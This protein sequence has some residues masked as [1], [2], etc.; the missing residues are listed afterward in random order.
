M[1]ALFLPTIRQIIELSD[2]EGQAFES[3]TQLRTWPKKALLSQQGEVCQEVLFIQQGLVRVFL[4][5][6]AGE[7]KT[8]HFAMPGSFICEYSSFLTQAPALYTLQALS[9]VE[10]VVMP[11]ATIAWGYDN[12]R[13]GDRFGRL[14]AEGY[15]VYL[16]NRVKSLYTQS[17][18]E[19][20]QQFGSLFPS[21]ESQIP[22]HYIASYL[23]IT[24]VHLSRLKQQARKLGKAQ[25]P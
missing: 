19:R 21:L 10:A 11:R 18:W 24:P 23:G 1:C 25:R 7:E 4:T 8:V 15:F 9:P 12:L 16:D 6:G 20:Y 17:A 22:Q 13:Q 2:S 3:R 14:V 5:D